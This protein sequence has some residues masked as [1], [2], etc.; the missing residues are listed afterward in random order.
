MAAASALQSS[1]LP[2]PVGPVKRK[3]EIAELDAKTAE[4]GFWDDIKGSQIVL[5]KQSSL[6]NKVNAYEKLQQDY[7]D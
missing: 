4:N 6:K 2:T 3:E 7:E 1:V 5:K